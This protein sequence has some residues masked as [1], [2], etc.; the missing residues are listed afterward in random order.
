[1]S[2][3]SETIFGILCKRDCSTGQLIILDE[4]QIKLINLFNGFDLSW[5][6]SAKL[7]RRINRFLI[8]FLELSN[9][10]Y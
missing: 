9:F 3:Q 5:Y 7:I 4:K 2:Q 1:M 6:S 8:D 10:L